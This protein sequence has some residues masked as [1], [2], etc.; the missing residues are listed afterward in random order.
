[1]RSELTKHA[2][3]T[4]EIKVS[5]PWVDV[6]KTYDQ[7]VTEAIKQIEVKGFRKGKA[8]RSLAEKKL[9]QEKVWQKTLEILLPNIYQQITQK[10]KLTPIISPNIQLLKAAPEN[11]LIVN[12][13]TAE[14]PVFK[15]GDYKQALSRLK[16][17]VGPKLWVPE[18]AKKTKDDAEKKDETKKISLEQ[19][20]DQLLAVS[21][22]TIPEI[23]LQ[24]QTSRNLTQLIDQVNQVG[25]TIQQYARSKGKTV[26]EIRREKK[27]E[28]E[29]TTKLEFILEKIA[30]V[31]KIT[32]ENSE[33]DKVI[34]QT[35]DQREKDNLRQQRY[36]IASLLRRQKTLQKLQTF[37]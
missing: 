34:E 10:E 25:M 20:L 11:E 17:Q 29:K 32:V 9:D 21:E 15:L 1:M 24:Q 8:P 33:I 35:K 14:K 13:T 6:K 22:L 26:E 30:D 2:D 3:G 27:V 16:Q 31:E 19:I 28:A 23:I 12:I 7:I 36:F 5:L 18:S 4:I 37:V